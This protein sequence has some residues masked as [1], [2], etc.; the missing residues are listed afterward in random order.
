MPTIQIWV[1]EDDMDTLRRLK[2]FFEHKQEEEFEGKRYRRFRDFSRGGKRRVIRRKRINDSYI[3]RLT[4][5]SYW[6]NNE[7]QIID[8]EKSEYR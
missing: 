2:N 7:V 6:V 3:L 5:H 1:T 8:F 4:L